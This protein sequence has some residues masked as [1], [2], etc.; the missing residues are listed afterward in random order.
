MQPMLPSNKLI[1]LFFFLKSVSKLLIHFN[2]IL[3]IAIWKNSPLK[4][5]IGHQPLKVVSSQGEEQ[6][7]TLFPRPGLALRP[8]GT[9]LAI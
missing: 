5:W 3:L 9:C 2:F 4:L 1:L 7:Q 8:Q 6:P